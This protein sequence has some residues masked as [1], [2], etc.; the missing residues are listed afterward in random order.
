MR[1]LAVRLEVPGTSAV[2]VVATVVAVVD[3]DDPGADVVETAVVVVATVLDGTDVVDMT[4]TFGSGATTG[5]SLSPLLQ[6]ATAMAAPTSAA[7]T[8]LHGM[9]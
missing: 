4:R 8:R 9:G 2:V 1:S 3:V 5:S 6:A 7:A